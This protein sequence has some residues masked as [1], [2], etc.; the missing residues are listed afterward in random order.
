MSPRLWVK[1]G[2]RFLKNHFQVSLLPS[3]EI[4]LL[5]CGDSAEPE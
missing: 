4:S 3:S 1:I 2:C 5:A